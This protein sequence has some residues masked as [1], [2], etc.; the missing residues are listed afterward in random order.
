MPNSCADLAHQREHVV[1]R[2]RV[3]AV[4]RLVEEHQPRVVHERLGEL[5]PLLHAGRVAA[6]RPVALLGQPDVAQH[7]GGALARRG[8]R[9]PG[10]LAHVDDEVAGRH[11]GAA[12]SRARACSRPA[13]GSPRP[14]WRRRGRAR[15]AVPLVAGDQPEQDLDQ[16]R[17]ARAV[18]AD[19]P[20]H[21]RADGHVEVVE[22]R[23]ARVVLGQSGRRDHRVVTAAGA[24][25]SPSTP[26][27]LAAHPRRPVAH[28]ATGQGHFRAA[29]TT[30]RA[31][32]CTWARW[33]GPAERLGVDLVDVLGAGRPGGE[34]GR[35]GASP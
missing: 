27:T 17:L 5:G 16:R 28:Q 13:R 11:V 26:T 32:S 33:S 21:A 30:S 8:V 20:G 15:V 19:Q 10:H 6:H 18:G 9:Q 2:G 25:P 7:V 14:R 34:P 12:G 35:L 23:D 3:E 1:A 22:R 29:E 24:P 31:S 4:G